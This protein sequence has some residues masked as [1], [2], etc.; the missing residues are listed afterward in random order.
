MANHGMN[1][2]LH[3]VRGIARSRDISALS[4]GELLSRFRAKSDEQAFEAIVRRHGPM[5]FGVCRRILSDFHDADDAFQATFVVLVKRAADFEKC[6]TVG[7]WLHGVAVRTALKAKTMAAQ[8]RRKETMAARPEA[9]NT[10][11][12]DDIAQVLDVELSRLPEKF[13]LPLILCDMEGKT[14]DDVAEELSWPPGTVASRLAR[15]RAMLADR[16]IRRGI[17]LTAALLTTAICQRTAL[18]SVPSALMMAS[19]RAASAM[20]T[21][22]TI[23][24]LVS[25]NASLLA[26]CVLSTMF[27]CKLRSIFTVACVAISF[28]LASGVGTYHFGG[29][30]HPDANGIENKQAL[31]PRFDGNAGDKNTQTKPTQHKN[32]VGAQPEAGGTP[33]DEKKGAPPTKPTNDVNDLLE[34]MRQ[35]NQKLDDALAGMKKRTGPALTVEQ[36]AALKKLQGNWILQTVQGHD[37]IIVPPNRLWSVKSELFTLNWPLA[38]VSKGGQASGALL[39]PPGGE[40]NDQRIAIDMVFA[41][42]KGPRRCPAI[43]EV[44]GDTVQICVRVA[45]QGRP[46]DF[47]PVRDGE[48]LAVRLKRVSTE[49]P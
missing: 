13:R 29:D 41:S 31:A 27:W 12:F 44:S 4:D 24:G 42:E 20:A 1:S 6:Q 5:V 15:A 49:A 35:A 48:V 46:K 39:F 21:G 33:I 38:Q 8:R 37:Q 26:D 22:Q 30:V 23:T 3:A 19:V 28:M 7:G 9:T 17:V 43:L 11:P 32:P 16:L 14:R 36:T 45:G 18:A 2:A 40:I 10:A 25:T 47:M 34:K